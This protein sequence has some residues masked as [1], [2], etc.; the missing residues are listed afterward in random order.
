VQ[1]LAVHVFDAE[2]GSYEQVSSALQLLVVQTVDSQAPDV[3]LQLRSVPQ[4]VDSTQRAQTESP[5][6]LTSQ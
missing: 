4:I 3:V 2:V 1:E 5:T 6:V